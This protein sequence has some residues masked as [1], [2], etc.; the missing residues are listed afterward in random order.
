MFQKLVKYS[1]VVLL[2]SALLLQGVSEIAA[3]TESAEPMIRIGV[4][5]EKETITLGSD[6]DYVIKDKVTGDVLF[7]GSNDSVEITLGS[8][9]EIKNNYRLQVAFT[10]S[11]PYVADWL[12]RAKNAGH[13]TYVEPYNNG[14]RLFI[15]EFPADASFSDRTAFKND[16]IRLGLAASDAFWKVVTIAEGE[17]KL[18][19]TSGSEAK[20]TENSVVIESSNDHIKINGKKY[21]GLGE[22]AFNSKGT[23]AGI[24]E[25]PMEE[26][27]Y[28]VVPRELPP[29]PY[30]EVEAQK[31]QA[32]AA[33]TYAM[34]N[35]GKRKADGYDLLPTTSDQVYA[36]FEAEHPVSNQAV[37]ETKGIVATYE[38]KLITAVFNS[39]SGGYSANNEDVWNSEAVPYLRGVPDAERG[40]A[41]EHVPSLE[42]F[43]NHKNAKSLRAAAEGD[44]ESD[45]SRY[46]RW[47]FE[48]TSEEISNVLSTY[49]NTEVGKVYEINVL[50]RS[51][52][53]RVL[54]IEFVTEAGNFYEYKDRV[55]TALKY[56]NASG[57]QASLLSTLFFIEPVVDNK[58]KEVIGFKTYGGG[59]GHGVGMSQT[60]A[61][62][63]AVK[64][65][66]F[67][68]ILKHYYQGIE[69]EKNY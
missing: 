21:R 55:R 17:S 36:G 22:V 1:F 33:R 27:L 32:V 37:D 50:E 13:P 29:V 43:K 24:N 5:P 14:Y 67:D 69:L 12:D 9:A 53:G 40:K 41:L 68:E 2:V 59:W 28:G 62:G 66:T 65:Y 49:Y 44:Y 56:I 54:E 19:V 11:E 16:M 48:W 45:W 51:N 52:S 46:H 57:N 8:S 31:S 34:S 63:M 15:G 10:S 23:L 18:K 38:G 25:L 58:T 4:E 42:V 7:E 30:G 64:G 20:A 35:L 26:Y 47:N 39:T 3:T 6:G 61:M 60:G